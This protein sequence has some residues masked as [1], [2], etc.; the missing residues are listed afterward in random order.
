MWKD[1][2]LHLRQIYPKD[3]ICLSCANITSMFKEIDLSWASITSM[4]DGIEIKKIQLEP[5]R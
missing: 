3:L 2:K 5:N 1:Q 4:F